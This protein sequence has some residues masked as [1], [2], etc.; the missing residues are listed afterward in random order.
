MTD[1]E[2]L[3]ALGVDALGINFWPMSKRYLPPADAT[4]LH[5]LA[6]RILRVGVFVNAPAELPLRLLRDGMLDV[7]QLHGDESIADAKVLRMAGMP[8]IKAIG[9][10]SRADLAHATDYGAAAILLDAHAPGIYGGTGEVFDWDVA[11]G[12]RM[13][14]PDVPVVLAGGIVPENAALAARSVR[15]VALDVASGAEFSPGIKDF[16]K[17]RAILENLTR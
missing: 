17:V 11:I 4:W 2:Q 7:I 10:K 16:S 15:P 1:A 6:G 3:A 13:Q 14:H 5:D 8:F 9:I 12:F